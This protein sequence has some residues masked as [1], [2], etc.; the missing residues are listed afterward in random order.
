MRFQEVLRRL[1]VFDE[2]FV[3]HEAGISFGPVSTSTLD[4]KTAAL[5]QLAV[6]V[7]IGSAPVCL[8]WGTG[9]A[10]AAG[11]AEDEIADTLLAVIPVAGID[12]VVSAAPSVATAL[13]YDVE[14]ALEELDEGE[15]VRTGR[16]WRD[17]TGSAEAASRRAPGVQELP[18]HVVNSL[19]QV[20]LILSAAI[21]RP[22]GI[23][24]PGIPRALQCLDETIREIRDHVFSAAR[25]GTRPP[26]AAPDGD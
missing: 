9:R 21:D 15:P 6:G 18:D 4:P 26:L 2:R 16:A 24:V 25:T 10:L 14:A 5:L 23:A 22:G 17:L 20:G 3:E 8:E 7:A 19:F 13:E 1:A 11:A 12:R